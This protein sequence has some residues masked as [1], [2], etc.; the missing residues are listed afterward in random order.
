MNHES[1]YEL[2]RCSIRTVLWWNV[3]TAS[4]KHYFQQKLSYWPL[5]TP[6]TYLVLLEISEATYEPSINFLQVAAVCHCSSH[7]Y[8]LGNRITDKAKKVAKKKRSPS[9][10][11]LHQPQREIHAGTST[12]FCCPMPTLTPSWIWSQELKPSDR[13]KH[14]LKT[15]LIR[16]TVDDRT[17]EDAYVCHE[18]HA[19]TVTGPQ[20]VFASNFKTL[21]IL[22]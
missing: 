11:N 21:A 19:C 16:Y 5:T 15:M 4:H 14:S 10:S 2:L 8:K 3:D 9:L 20:F 1:W 17:N 7:L 12:V 18:M 13:L 22:T 6:V